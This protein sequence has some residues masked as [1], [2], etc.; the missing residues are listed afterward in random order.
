MVPPKLNSKLKDSSLFWNHPLDAVLCHRKTVKDQGKN[1]GKTAKSNL[2]K[3]AHLLRPF[4]S[5]PPSPCQKLIDCCDNDPYP[6][7][8]QFMRATPMLVQEREN[9]TKNERGKNE[10]GIAGLSTVEIVKLTELVHF[11]S[12]T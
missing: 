3:S 12:L 7:F 2:C 1:G 11:S 10:I 6:V 4:C 8:K 9:E 5:L